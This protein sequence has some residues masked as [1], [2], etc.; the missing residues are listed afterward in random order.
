[1]GTAV[2]E[3][4]KK[5]GDGNAE[6][7]EPVR[8]IVFISHANPEDNPAAAWFA[9]QL[10][11]LGYDVWCDLRNTHAGESE[12][13]LKI[14]KVI[15]NEAA[16]FVYILSNTSCDF[17]R[18]KGIYKEVQAADNLRIDNFILPLRI[19]KL[20][21][22]LPILLN[23]G[24]YIAAENWAAGLQELVARLHKDGVPRR[25]DIDFEKITTWW[26][27]LAAEKLIV[28][29]EDEE[30]VSNILPLKALPQ[31]V[32]LIRVLSEQNP[33]TGFETLRKLL[34]RDPSF[35]AHG[36]YA[37]SFAGP[38][39]FAA[40]G[41][42]L[43]FEAAYAVD[44]K[45]FLSSGHEHSGIIPDTAQNILT[46]LLSEAWETFMAAKGLSAK[47]QTR[48]RRRTWYAHDGLVQGNRASLSE[49][50]RRRTAIQLVGSVSHYKKTY[51][52]HFG[53]LGG[54][55][56]RV[57]DGIVLTPKAVITPL[58]NAAD[59]ELPV[60][61]DDKKVLKKLNWW[62]PHWRQKLLAMLG[63]LGGEQPQIVIP[64]GY[65]QLVLSSIPDSHRCSV[66]FSE[67]S[68]DKV[69]NQA[70]E[71]LLEHAPSS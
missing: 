10:T 1:M 18:K 46:Y 61:I 66:S 38:V 43:E 31:T 51:R 16:K 64:V 29:S 33:I 69:I 37:V 26:P 20:T 68:D 48:G 36:D 32:H 58:Y 42:G 15:E 52:W 70:M 55:D 28:R 35:Y 45:D 47:P 25:D 59:G 13:W 14:Q 8:R 9:T 53:L 27:A 6:A 24:L 40:I 19:E 11:L 3:K 56:L 34:P 22:S 30:L 57:H 7:P 4:V 71:A 2:I 44:A 23:T 41:H 54:V 67:V 49:P 60:P 65:Q 17:E 50:G 63:W 12:F 62:T 5:S 21:R 39:D